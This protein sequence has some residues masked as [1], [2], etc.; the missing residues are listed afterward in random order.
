M[1]TTIQRYVQGWMTPHPPRTP[2]PPTLLP[3][4]IP[5]LPMTA[6]LQMPEP[7]ASLSTPCTHHQHAGDNEGRCQADRLS[8][9]WDR[10]AAPEQRASAR[11]PYDCPGSA[12]L[13]PQPARYQSLTASSRLHHFF[14]GLIGQSTCR[15]LLVLACFSNEATCGRVITAPSTRSHLKVAHALLEHSHSNGWCLRA[16]HR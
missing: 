16:D 3:S 9:F 12:Q 4:P 8:L 14:H 7:T 11:L 2:T 13:D 10:A 1:L 6:V 5:T 15:P